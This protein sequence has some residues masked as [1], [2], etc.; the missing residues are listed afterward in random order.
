MMAKREDKL[1]LPAF[2]YR[3]FPEFRFVRSREELR[4]IKKA[5]GKRPKNNLRRIVYGVLY[6]AVMVG[7]CGL[8]AVLLPV[9]GAPRWSITPLVMLA[10]AVM[11]ATATVFLL[12]RPYVKFLREYL[13]AQGVPVC[14]KCG[15]DLRGQVE[16][17]CPECGTAFDARLLA[18]EPEQLTD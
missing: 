12:Y 7:L 18:G 9:L 1:D 15:Y 2:S 3:L 17:R 5:F 4:A 6:L 16:A 14:L 11:G 10:G 13:Q 8:M